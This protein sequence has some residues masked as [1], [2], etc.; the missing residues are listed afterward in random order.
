MKRLFK[1]ATLALFASFV[2]F[3]CSTTKISETWKDDGYQGAPFSD[4]FVIGVAKK[5][6]TRRSFENMFVEKLQAAGVQAV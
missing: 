5:E 2:F 1:C 4:L 3:S 6:T